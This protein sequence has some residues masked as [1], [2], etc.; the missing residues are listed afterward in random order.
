MDLRWEFEADLWLW[1]ARA[2]VWTFVS[3]P[4]EVSE[5]VADSMLTPPRGFGSVPV[6]VEIGSSRWSTSV[7]PDAGRGVYIMPVK[8]A[9]RV[10]EGVDVGDV[11]TVAI[12]LDTR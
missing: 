4:A 7:F 5:E 6:V 2:D 11:V 10:R 12:E 9:V 8:K 1:T 3:L